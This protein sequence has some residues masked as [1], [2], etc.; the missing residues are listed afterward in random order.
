MIDPSWMVIYP[1]YRK[2]ILK[3]KLSFKI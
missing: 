3:E 1:L 2:S